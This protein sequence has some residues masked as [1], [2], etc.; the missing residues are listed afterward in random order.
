[1]DFWVLVEFGFAQ[2]FGAT[3]DGIGDGNIDV[4]MVLQS[5]A[6]GPISNGG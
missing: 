3:A 4:D 2:A 6:R 5:L 1:M